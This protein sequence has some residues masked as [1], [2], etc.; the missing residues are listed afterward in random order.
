MPCRPTSLV[1]MALLPLADSGCRRGGEARRDLLALTEEAEVW[2]SPAGRLAGD[3][4]KPLRRNGRLAVE[5]GTTLSYY[6]HVP[7]RARLRIESEAGEADAALA[8]SLQDDERSEL[9]IERPLASGGRGSDEARLDSWQGRLGRLRLSNGAGGGRLWI[10]RLEFLFPA[11]H[12]TERATA[13]PTGPRPNIIIYLVDTLRADG[14]GAYGRRAPTSPRFDA[15]AKEAILFEDAWAQAS[16]TVPTTASILTGQHPA[17]HGADRPDRKLPDEAVTLAEALKRGGYRT[18]AYVANHLVAKHRGFSQGFDDWNGGEPKRYGASAAELSA[19]A[20]AWIDAA[21]QPFFLYVH[22]ME[23]H[24]PYAPPAEDAAPFASAY[25]GE[26]DTK[27]LLRRGHETGLP[28]RARRFLES[29]YLG[30]VRCNDRAFGALLDGLR[31]RGLLERSAV[32]FTADHGEEF[33]DHGSTQHGK[34]LYTELLHVPLAVRLPGARR[35]GTRER[36]TVQ[37]VD[38]YPTLLGLAGLPPQPGLPGRDLSDHWLGG[39]AAEPPS[40]LF[41]QQCFTVVDKAA[42]RAGSLKLIVNR[43]A[44]LYWRAGAQLEL[45]DLARDPAE[46]VNLA[47]TRP[48]AVHGLLQEL[49]RFERFASTHR[50]GGDESVPLSAEEQDALRALGYIQ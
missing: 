15:F 7:S 26:R 38:L 39:A 37:Q 19:R 48:I 35:G 47:S 33:W 22:T 46:A 1:L 23:P 49:D 13:E 25:G 44:R 24:A 32:L 14:L 10:D 27:A 2:S 21:P 36:G 8:V 30:E 28:P 17:V 6:V 45:Y 20:L 29:Q 42:V 31:E 18:G 16:W 4:R 11:P 41:S 5:P 50:M 40:L 43:D 12:A 9:L 3:A 34:T